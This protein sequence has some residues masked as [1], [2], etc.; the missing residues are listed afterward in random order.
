MLSTENRALIERFMDAGCY[1]PTDTT[2]GFTDKR[3]N[4]LLDA[5]KAMARAEEGSKQPV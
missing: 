3:L 1:H 5:A 2:F 4:D